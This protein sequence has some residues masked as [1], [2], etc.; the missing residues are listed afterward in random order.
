[1][2]I[3]STKIYLIILF[4]LF[5]TLGF[6]QHK[7]FE[8]A[9]NFE[10]IISTNLKE[11][12]K[13]KAGTAIYPYQPGTMTYFNKEN[14]QIQLPIQLKKRGK[15][16]LDAGF[17]TFPPVWVKFDSTAR[18]GT[19]FQ[20][21]KKLKLV[22]ECQ[23][24]KSFEQYVYRE[25]LVYK[26][27]NQLTDKSFRVKLV[28]VIFQDEIKSKKQIVQTAFFIEPIS[29]IAKRNDLVELE[30]EMI[31]QKSTVPTAMLK[32]SFFQFMIGNQDWS[33]P[34]LHNIKLLSISDL[35][36]VYAIPY[37]FDLTLMVQPPYCFDEY[38]GEMKQQ[39]KWN[40]RGF[41]RPELIYQNTIDLFLN[42]KAVFYQ[43][44]EEF[45]LLKNTYRKECLRQ[46]D[47]FY[48]ILESPDK[49]ISY[50]RAKAR[51]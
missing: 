49:G 44:Y 4:C 41:Q 22:T 51:K 24:S 48:D 15:S 11:L 32:T 38:T 2:T 29:S 34:G 39:L 37:D 45:P 12:T 26:L 50:F 47:A 36:K 40:Y 8:T 27:Y 14:E 31:H 7:F 30:K 28:K 35:E 25:Y 17:C 20:D 10:I 46:L 33:V 43:L 16:R 18:Q 21:F 1:M 13:I 42:K 6:T 19:I 9:D 5:Y 3:N 23:P